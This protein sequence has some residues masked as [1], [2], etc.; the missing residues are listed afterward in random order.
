MLL[1]CSPYFISGVVE[2]TRGAKVK[3]KNKRCQFAFPGEA[4]HHRY[5]VI[6]FINEPM[7]KD[8]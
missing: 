8:V 7:K 3:A 1:Y 2:D 5:P 4:H 6:D